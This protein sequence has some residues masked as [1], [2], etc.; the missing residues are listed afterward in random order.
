MTA[1]VIS[2]AGL[3]SRLGMNMPK[4]LL[5]I[6]SG[7]L[8]DYQLALLGPDADVRLVVGYMEKDVVSY[9]GA[10]WPNVSYVRNPAYASTSNTFSL[11]LASRLLKGPFVAIDGDLLI[12]PASFSAFLRHCASAQRTTVGITRRTTDEAVGVQLDDKGNDNEGN[13]VRFLLATE[14]NYSSC[15]FEWSGIAYFKDVEVQP[16]SRFVFEELAK[17]LPLPAFEIVCYEIDT[18]GDLARATERAASVDITIPD[19]PSVHIPPTIA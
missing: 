6:K 2:A 10:R 3:G 11:Y 13:I 8:I 19:M 12:E 1:F 18:L 7:R 17:S 15:A 4:C 5:P 16:N 14:S 9:V